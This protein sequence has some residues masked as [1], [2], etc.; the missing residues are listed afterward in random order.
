MDVNDTNDRPLGVSIIA[1]WNVVVAL[2]IGLLLVVAS[3]HPGNLA[4]LGR[5][6]ATVGI[7]GK[8]LLASV[9][10]ISALTFLA[11]IGLWTGERLG[12][13]LGSFCSLY[14]VAGILTGIPVLAR[15]GQHFGQP[16]LTSGR[17]SSLVMRFAINLS[18][19]LYLMRADVMLYLDIPHE[20]RFKYLG[21]LG[22]G[23]VGTYGLSLLVARAGVG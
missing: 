12:W 17:L 2:G 1:I 3:L 7:S 21:Y 14:G 22:I 11:G 13:W 15:I 19:L 10:V 4:E 20:H 6:F 9:V 8:W 5:G 18:I 23:I 16:A